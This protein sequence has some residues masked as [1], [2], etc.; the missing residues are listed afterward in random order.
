MYCWGG[1]WLYIRLNDELK[2]VEDSI[3]I[4]KMLETEG[5]RKWAY[6][7]VNDEHVFL[8]HYKTYN[9]KK[10]DKVKVI[11]SIVGG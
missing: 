3:T 7:W 2:K 6:V 11:D 1:H 4:E 8:K 10:E 5:F 9:L